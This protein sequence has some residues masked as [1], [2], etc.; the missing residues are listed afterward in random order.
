VTP[1]ALQDDPTPAR[2][3][4]SIRRR[5]ASALAGWSLA[6]ALAVG[7][8]IVLT[9][10]HEVDELLDG[11][12]KSSAELLSAL[13]VQGAAPDAQ[14]VRVGPG[15]EHFAWQITGADGTLQGRSARAPSAPWAAA[16][17][18]GFSDRPGWRV[19]GVA[20]TD[21]RMFYAAQTLDE[22]REARFDVGRGAVLATLLIA[23]VVHVWLRLRLRTELQPLQRLSGQLEAL[24]FD[25]AGAV[26]P[27]ALGPAQRR[28]LQPV[29]D[30]LGALIS[31]LAAR[32]AS[33]RAFAAHA[34]HALRTPLAGIDA[35]LA[36]AL[37]D[38][39]P[40]LAERLQRVRGAA[41][42][43]QGV[44]AALL[45][46]F[47][48]GAG[49]QRG[50]VDLAAMVARLPTSSLQVH[51]D[52]AASMDADADLLAAALVNLLDNAQRHGARQVWLDQP[53]PNRLRLRDDG[54]GVDPARRAALQRA[55]NAQAYE[56]GPG[57]GLMLAD[58]VARAHGGQLALPATGAGFAVELDL[59]TAEADA[60]TT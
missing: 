55:L 41:H 24:S 20:L 1:A 52:A 9:A 46:L 30:A 12:L 40:E 7:A 38:C 6:W 10:G 35:Q 47:R 31:R 17:T 21:G 5:L 57:L 60:A 4:P 36:V 42:R 27:L 50:A 14:A 54:P 29:H 26:R 56:A 48:A 11:A 22:R 33:E 23:A 28:E 44:V 53:S 13:V 37:R 58:R 16:A 25:D 45:G 49:P 15:R 43:L 19:Y 51:V 59:G 39:P 3:A 2:G 18:A 8:A 32:V 34:A